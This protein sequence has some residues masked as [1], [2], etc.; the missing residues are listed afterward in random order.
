MTARWWEGPLLAVDL[1]TTGKDPETARIVTAACIAV[2]P[3]G[4]L[5]RQTWLADPGVEIPAEATAVHGV[6]TEQARADGAPAYEVVRQIAEE[7]ETAWADPAIPV[8]AMN[9]AYD[10]T[11]IQRELVRHSFEPLQIGPVLDPMVI[12]RAIDK[13]RKGSRKLEALA[14]HYGVRLDG[15][16]SA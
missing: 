15:A 3:S 2:G 6:S 14:T 10:L 5:S 9:A 16:H 1:E 13:W 7:I 12:D 8:V 11:I 4:V